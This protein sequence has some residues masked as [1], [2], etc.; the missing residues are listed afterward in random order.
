MSSANISFNSFEL[1]AGHAISAGNISPEERQVRIDLAAA[2]RLCAMFGW[3]DLIYSHI[4]A[5]VPGPEHHF[6]INPLGLAF[7]EITASNLVKIDLDGNLIGE[8]FY[9]PNA[10]GFVILGAIHMAREDAGAILHLHT[11]AGMALSMCQDGL[12]PMTQHAMRF[13]GRIGY[14]DYEGIALSTEERNR[15]V[16]NLKQHA[17]LIFRNHGTLTV[18][19]TVGHAFVEMFYLEKS[20]RSQL[21]AQASGQRLSISTA[22]VAILTNAQWVNDLKNPVAREWPSLL[23]KLDRL[24]L[25]YRD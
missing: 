21:L 15:I 1:P 8:S 12:L 10:P 13:H 22:E 14:H 19:K 11:E 3:D 20:A 24:D 6:L 18:G 17:A 25:S 7:D 4:S 23:R 5:R 16:V 9:R 2:Y